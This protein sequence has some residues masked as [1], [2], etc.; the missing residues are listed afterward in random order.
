MC[1]LG[2]RKKKNYR[3][4]EKYF[5][6]FLFSFFSCFVE[7]KGMRKQ[8]SW[9]GENVLSTAEKIAP[10]FSPYIRQKYFCSICCTPFIFWPDVGKGDWSANGTHVHTPRSP[11]LF[12]PP[13]NWDTFSPSLT[14][15]ETVLFDT[16]PI[17]VRGWWRR[18]TWNPALLVAKKCQ[19][20]PP[21][22]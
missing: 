12:V 5:L 8:Q 19:F 9:L 22:S 11:P 21:K 15:G 6:F 14:F 13:E 7:K 4:T 1:G 20:W 18:P 3:L 2:R 16:P 10:L 17:F